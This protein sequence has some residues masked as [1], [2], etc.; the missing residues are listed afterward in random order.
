MRGKSRK[1]GMSDFPEENCRSLRREVGFPGK[2]GSGGVVRGKSRKVGK[3]D[4]LGK[5]AGLGGAKSD[6]PEKP[7]QTE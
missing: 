4:F 2:V 6:F 1:V 5:I 3:S 7:D